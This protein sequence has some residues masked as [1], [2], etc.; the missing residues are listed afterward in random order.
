[1]GCLTRAALL[2]QLDH[3]VEI[4]ITGA[5]ASCE[6]VPA[7][8]GNRLA[9]RDYVELAGITR[10]KEGVNAQALLDEGHETRDLGAVVLS[11]RA[12]NDFNLHFVLRS[13]SCGHLGNHSA[14]RAVAL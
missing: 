5:K 2:E 7:P 14:R 4:G 3:A 6:P 9:V 1:M 8:L 10:R 13:G 11:S 12:V